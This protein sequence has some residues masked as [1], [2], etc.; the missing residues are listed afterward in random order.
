MNTLDRYIVRNFLTTAFLF[1]VVLM[2]LR[3]VADLSMNIDEFAK[4]DKLGTYTFGKKVVHVL[5]YYGYQSL[6][7]FTEL[8]GVIIVAAAAFTLAMMNHTN[9]LTAILASGV[10]LHRVT[11]PIVICAMVMGGLVVVDQELIIPRVAQKLVMKRGEVVETKK[12]QVRLIT[13]GAGTVWWAKSYHA[14]REEMVLP[15]IAIRDK[16][17]RCLAVA[18][19]TSARPHKLRG[20]EGWLIADAYLVASEHVGRIWRV[21]PGSTRISSAIGPLDILKKARERYRLEYGKDVP[22]DK[23]TA[24]PGARV[25]D[26]VYGM[27]IQGDF[28]PDPPPP[29]RSADAGTP[30]PAEDRDSETAWGGR[31][32][33]P[34]FAFAGPNGEVLGC[35]IAESARWTQSEEEEGWFWELRGGGMFYPSDMTPAKLLLRQSS[36]WM[37]YMSTSDLARLARLERIP[38]RRAAELIKHVRFTAPIN[39][40]VMLLLGLPF[41]LSRERNIRAS[42]TLCV[43]TVMTFFAFVYICRYMGLNPVLGAWLPILSFGPLAVTTLY[44]LKT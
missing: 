5:S 36:D 7:Y 12:F 30:R 34:T 29:G 17:L 23:L 31:L 42:V 25:F 24:W 32:E 16:R 35:F 43:L 10:S 4:L 11:L 6:V 14:G 39:N 19:G 37:D 40:L 27:T 8:G 33:K 20:R 18:F 13:D 22:L 44:S 41:I 15:V 28:I 3:V 21:A 38:D 2:L 26:P 9:E 1:F